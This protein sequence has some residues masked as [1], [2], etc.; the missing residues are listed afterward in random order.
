MT[1][2]S[3][4]MG[5]VGLTAVCPG[6]GCKRPVTWNLPNVAAPL[7]LFACP[8]CKMLL[9]GDKDGGMETANKVLK[10]LRRAA[11]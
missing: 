6:R 9:V 10:R 11:R 2:P 1:E 5:V 7:A 4:A 3:E 8:H